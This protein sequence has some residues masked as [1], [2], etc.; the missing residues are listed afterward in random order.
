MKRL[1]ILLGMCLMPLL[2]HAQYLEYYQML[3]ARN[4]AQL[5]QKWNEIYSKTIVTHDLYGTTDKYGKDLIFMKIEIVCLKGIQNCKVSVRN[6]FTNKSRT[7][8]HKVASMEYLLIGFSDEWKISQGDIFKI[9]GNGLQT[10]E[11]KLPVSVTDWNEYVAYLKKD[12]NAKIEAAQRANM[13]PYGGQP[14]LPYGTQQ[15]QVPSTTTR[16]RCSACKGTGKCGTC[17]GD[18]Y[19]LSPFDGTRLECPNCS[20]ANGRICT[21]CNGTGWWNF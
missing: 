16:I 21:V 12:T 2:L 6:I 3:S 1:A 7:F 15:Q 10:K 14:F 11:I 5:Q 17:N 20:A 9:E 19:Y 13:N 4:N 8:L 18:G